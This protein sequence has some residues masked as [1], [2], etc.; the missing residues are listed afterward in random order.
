MNPPDIKLYGVVGNPIS[1]SLSPKIHN[2]WIENYNL[3]AFYT[4]LL[5]ESEQNFEASIK[6]LPLLGFCGVNITVPYKQNAYSICDELSVEAQSIGAVNCLH[7]TNNKI[8]GYNTDAFGFLYPLQCKQITNALVIGAG[9]ASRAVIY[10]LKTIGCSVDIC[11]RTFS[12]AIKLTKHFGCNAIESLLSQINLEKYDI[13]INA[14]SLGLSNEAIELNY[15]TA[16]KTCIFYDI[17]YKKNSL[18]PFLQAAKA[19]NIT[20][21]LDGLAMLYAQAAKSF[22]IWHGIIPI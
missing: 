22:E 15:K 19:H 5:I 3:K 10:S 2:S 20:T 6:T 1:H 21:T 9:G 13:I 16:G 17:I 18:T 12:E 8:I 14:T 7:F 4:P 11:N